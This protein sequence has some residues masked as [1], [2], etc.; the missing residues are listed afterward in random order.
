MKRKQLNDKHTVMYNKIFDTLLKTES[1]LTDFSP[2]KPV[3]W[4]MLR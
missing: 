3:H 2:Y 4:V 1:Q